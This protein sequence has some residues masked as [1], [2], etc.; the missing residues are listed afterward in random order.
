MFRRAVLVVLGVCSLFNGVSLEAQI[1]S[2]TNPASG[3]W[4]D[5]HWSL[6]QLPGPGQAVSIE[7]P[8]WKAIA[9]GSSTVQ[10]FPQSLRPDTIAI[11]SPTN[12]YN[13][14]LL[15]YAGFRTPLSV[16]GLRI[17]SNAALVTLSSALE[18][19]DSMGG[20]SVGGALNQ[21]DFS[22]VSSAHIQ[23]GD[24]GPGAYNLTNGTVAASA[25]LSLGG[26]FP[27]HF[28]QFGG[29]NYTGN[30]QLFTSGEYDMF[31]GSLTTS[32]IIYG[33]GGTPSGNFIQY[34]GVAKP[35]VVYLSGGAYLLA[36]G[37]F[38]S[39]EVLLPGVASF[40][41]FPASAG[42]LQTGG[43][44]FTTLLSIGNWPP[45]L[46]NGSPF[47]GY[48]L[49]NGV[50]VTSSSA[51]GPFGSFQQSDGAHI[52]D[53]LA[54]HGDQTGPTWASY[55]SYTL[56]G[57]SLSAGS[58]DLS[59]GYFTQSGG[60][61]Q[62]VGD[63]TL[64]WKSWYNSTFQLSGGL[65]QSSNA[66]VVCNPAG[67]GGF[68]Q[69]G[70]TQIVSNL[71]SVS[72]ADVSWPSVA[73]SY[74]VDFLLTGGQLVA[75]NI[76]VD[77]AA[78]FHHRGGS[79]INTGMLTLANG[80]WEANTNQQMLGKLLLGIS[81]ANN[82]S[83]IFPSSPASLYFAN[84]GSV[85]WS[86]QAL[87]TIEHWNGSLAGGGPHQLFFGND[88]SGLTA[89]QLAQIQFHDPARTLGTYPATILPNGEVVPTQVLVS[90]HI[91][92]GLAL[93]WT[94]GMILQTSTNA[95]GPFHDITAPTATS[96]TVTFSE[97]QR[98]F[99]LHSVSKAQAAFAKY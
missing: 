35:E 99:R 83:I 1:N 16:Y 82:S 50:L 27:A 5:M 6:G 43:T 17:Y 98:F 52:T 97:P 48:A 95:A 8:G 32:N 92:N 39:S 37:I 91:G 46:M 60:T 75:Q 90:R 67:G 96:F 61:N 85:T 69:S 72:R 77:S 36:G 56:A 44:N 19:G 62:V 18:V 78:T 57:G 94:A 87:L 7:N 14:L 20:L 64:M 86:N 24:I 10:N 70:G 31:G 79:L 68:T 71:L 22:T 2:W 11:S 59:L 49:S 51:L 74:D 80:N 25:A 26:N 66:T 38:S 41:D 63:L 93:S 3:A 30:V 33:A 81:Q 45:P 47:G 9:I 13:V 73:N 23:V 55:A 21:G 65:L 12:S 42:F 29:S 34:G 84:S 58:L 54:L 53:S 28:N 40:H 76:R 88:S 15:N 4:E 89:Q